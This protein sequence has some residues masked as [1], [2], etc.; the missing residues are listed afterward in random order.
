MTKMKREKPITAG[1]LRRLLAALD[2][3]DDTL[4]PIT[5][6]QYTTWHYDNDLG[7]MRIAEAEGHPAALEL[8]KLAPA[9]AR[10]AIDSMEQQG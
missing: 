10:M 5:L 9:L 6:W 2:D 1:R 8:M 4:E 7:E 3:C